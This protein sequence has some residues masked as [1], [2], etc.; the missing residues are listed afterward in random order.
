MKKFIIKSFVFILLLVCTDFAIGKALKYLSTFAIGGDTYKN[1][2]IAEKIDEEIIIMGSSRASRHYVSSIFE[3][4]IGLTCYNAGVEGNGIIC[5]YAYTVMYTQHHTPEIIV[6]DVVKGYDLNINDNMKYL[7]RAKLFYDN[8]QIADIFKEIS[9]TEPYKMQSYM[10]RYNS[11]PLQIIADMI[12]PQ[13]D[14]IKGYRPLYGTIK[15][16]KTGGKENEIK[17]DSLKIKY[18][19]R[20][21]SL[22]KQKEIQ[23]FFAIS[24][25]YHQTNIINYSPVVSLAE[26]HNIPLFN[27]LN[28]TTFIGKQ[29]YFYDNV[30]LNNEG[31]TAYT[32]IIV[33]ELKNYISAN[34]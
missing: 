21:I 22:C 33:N 19:E 34:K 1:N 27:H 5:A 17:Y 20:F 9:S 7:G 15:H 25:N 29:H 2:Y 4:S 11:K 8:E 13:Q 6:F 14:E 32:N 16:P 28:D 31:A 10:Y 12:A 24:P 3:D 30:H 26:E 23:L 18:I